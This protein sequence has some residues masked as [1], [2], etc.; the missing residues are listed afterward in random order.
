LK[1]TVLSDA[2][3]LGNGAR[4][5]HSYNRVLITCFVLLNIS[6]SQSK[7]TPLSMLKG[8]IFD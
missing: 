4:Y 3:Y 2:D 1:V 6:K 8:V 7:M 5:R